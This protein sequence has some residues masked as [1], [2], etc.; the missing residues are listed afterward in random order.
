M[1]GRYKV[2]VQNNKLR[3][4]FYVNRNITIIR[5][6]S[7]TGKTT[8]LDMLREY[9]AEGS[10]SGITVKCDVECRVLGGR[11]WRE[12]LSFIHSSIVFIDE[13]NS[14]VR[15]QDFAFEVKNSGNYFVI[16]TRDDLPNLAY[17]V[18]EIYGLRVSNKYMGLKQCYNEFF[19]IYGKY[20]S[21]VIKNEKTLIVEDSNSGYDFFRAVK[22]EL[23]KCFSAHGK[24]NVITLLRR[25]FDKSILVIA[26]GAAF[27]CEM[28]K[29]NQIIESGGN[30]SLYLPESFEWIILKS[31]LIDGVEEI[32]SHPYDFIESSEFF[33]WERFF[34]DVLREKTR[35]TFLQYTKKEL[36]PVY[37][38]ENNRKKLLD[39]LEPIKL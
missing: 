9:E 10:A 4:E 27:G 16:V 8:L 24:S 36:N 37:L 31:G 38:E 20:D 14:F 17:S 29:I 23:S 1:K 12:N 18:D 13:G 3:Y 30:I 2:F 28:D 22:G 11:H 26:D 25:H 19:H 7:A 5:G 35:D 39:V 21:A 32:L 33:S 15:S 6:D 34:S